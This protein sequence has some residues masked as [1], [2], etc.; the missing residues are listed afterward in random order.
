MQF[1]SG[2]LGFFFAVAVMYLLRRDHI[3]ISHALFWVLFAAGGLMF[4]IFPK[5]SDRIASWFAVS[6]GPALVL[7][8][9]MLALVLRSIITDIQIT[10]IER[11]IKVL[12]QKLGLRDAEL[13]KQGKETSL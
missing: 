2:F 5:L 6:Y 13:N 9:A 4:G 8:V 10:R 7:V 3:K 11:D 12:S 1:T